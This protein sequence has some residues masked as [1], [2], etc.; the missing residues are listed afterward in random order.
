MKG[1]R[2][3]SREVSKKEMRRREREVMERKTT[4]ILRSM[5]VPPDNV[6]SKSHIPINNI[7]QDMILPSSL[8]ACQAAASPSPRSASPAAYSGG[9]I[10]LLA[11]LSWTDASLLYTSWTM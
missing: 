11:R 7:Q 1:E 6:S 8:S 2:P 10:R 9:C 3:R 5:R 4:C